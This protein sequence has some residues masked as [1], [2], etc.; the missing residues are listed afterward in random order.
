MTYFLLLVSRSVVCLHMT[1]ALILEIVFGVTSL[2]E[3][4]WYFIPRIKLEPVSDFTSE[5]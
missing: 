4:N 1:H 3:L 2:Q 5:P